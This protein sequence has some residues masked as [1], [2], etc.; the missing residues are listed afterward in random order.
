VSTVTKGAP[1]RARARA[2]AAGTA[3]ENPYVYDD[4]ARE[5]VKREAEGGVGGDRP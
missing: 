2:P 5:I 3:L 1:G 4:V